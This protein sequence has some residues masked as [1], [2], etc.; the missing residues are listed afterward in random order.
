MLALEINVGSEI[1]ETPDGPA[2]RDSDRTAYEPHGT[3]FGEEEPAHVGITGSDGLHDSD[4]T[5]AFENSH[6]QRIHD[7][8][9]SNGQG[10]AAEDREEPVEH[11]KELAHAAGRIDEG[12]SAESHFLD[13][14][15]NRRNLIGILYP[16]AE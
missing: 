5:P 4:F 9:G 13:G 11:G 10:Q 8:D 15:F 1:D 7:A 12:K 16:H 2:K 6:H 3:G 14:V